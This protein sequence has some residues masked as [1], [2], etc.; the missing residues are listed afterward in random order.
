MFSKLSFSHWVPFLQAVHGCEMGGLHKEGRRESSALQL[1]QGLRPCRTFGK[2]LGY[3]GWGAGAAESQ[4]RW[5]WQ[6]LCPCRCRAHLCSDTGWVSETLEWTSSSWLWGSCSWFYSGS[7]AWRPWV[8]YTLC[9]QSLSLSFMAWYQYRFTGRVTMVKW[10]RQGIWA[11]ESCWRMKNHSA[12]VSHHY[13]DLT[14]LSEGS[15]VIPR[16]EGHSSGCLP[17]SSGISQPPS[18]I[19]REATVLGMGVQCIHHVS[20]NSIW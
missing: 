18:L 14:V 8:I 16:G 9:L 2:P 17:P 7:P 6:H 12:D 13:Q 20:G 11:L 10:M 5:V 1:Q 15:S 3:H 19:Q 4:G